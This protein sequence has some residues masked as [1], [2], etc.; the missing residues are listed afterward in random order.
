MTGKGVLSLR[1]GFGAAVQAVQHEALDA[2]LWITATL[3]FSQLSVRTARAI[4]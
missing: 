2:W 1:A 4:A 3:R